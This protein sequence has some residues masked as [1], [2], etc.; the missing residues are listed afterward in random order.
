MSVAT[1]FV[2]RKSHEELV[3]RFEKVVEAIKAREII[4]ENRT[5]RAAVGYRH[6]FNHLL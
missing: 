4:Y 3:N 6:F 1:T 2:Y 5:E